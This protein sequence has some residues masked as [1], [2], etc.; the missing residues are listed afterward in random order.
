MGKMPNNNGIIL[1]DSAYPLL[2]WL[3]TPFAMVNNDAEK[4]FNCAHG[5]TRSTI[6]HLLKRRFACLNF[7]HVEP[8]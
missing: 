4:R 2:P 3:M 8:Q 1:G 5:R 7:L 6:E